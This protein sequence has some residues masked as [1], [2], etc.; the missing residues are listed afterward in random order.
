VISCNELVLL[1]EVYYSDIVNHI[2]KL[3]LGAPK[4]L[5]E[6]VPSSLCLHVRVQ[7]HWSKLWGG[8]QSWLRP[9][10]RFIS[11]PATWSGWVT[12]SWE[13]FGNLSCNS[14]GKRNPCYWYRTLIGTWLPLKTE[15][16]QKTVIFENLNV[17]FSLNT[18]H[19][20]HSVFQGH[21]QGLYKCSKFPLFWH[22][23]TWEVLD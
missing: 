18:V 1:F 2:A 7:M 4:Q 3:L 11:F 20:V 10:S 15:S 23:G 17:F 22:A 19:K 5:V 14:G 13:S 16:F 21:F 8:I 9:W 12:I 6:M